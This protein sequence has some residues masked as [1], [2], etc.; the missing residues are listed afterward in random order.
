MITDEKCQKAFLGGLEKLVGIKYPAELLPKVPQIL[1]AA[2]DLDLL[3]EDV[4]VAW[5]IKSSK[6]F[7][8]SEIN[9]EIRKQAGPFLQW[10]ATAEEESE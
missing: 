5:G 6:K 2:Y 4:I 7:V 9:R 1:K 8:P 10:L 3:D